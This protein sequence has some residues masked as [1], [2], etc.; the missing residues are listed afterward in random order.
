MIGLHGG[1]VFY[2]Y[3]RG[4]EQSVQAEALRCT[5]QKAP[6]GVPFVLFEV[7]MSIP[8]SFTPRSTRESK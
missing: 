8:I 4:Y 3:A 5:K 6:G 1:E 7:F 2:T